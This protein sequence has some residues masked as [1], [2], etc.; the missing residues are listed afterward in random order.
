V[1]IH[2]DAKG[3]AGLFDGEGTAVLSVGE[4]RRLYVHVARGEV[5]VSGV[6]LREGDGLK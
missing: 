6:A 4:E 2:Q 3:Y 1:L 5:N